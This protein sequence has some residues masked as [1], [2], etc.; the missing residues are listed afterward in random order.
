VT[1]TRARKTTRQAPRTRKTAAQIAA[2]R[3]AA[4]KP[5]PPEAFVIPT[6]LL[7]DVL[8]LVGSIPSATRVGQSGPSAGKV[9]SQLE[10]LKPLEPA[11]K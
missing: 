9:Y 2:E 3:A 11:K 6:P 1:N 8:R 10:L 7:A 4:E 5:K